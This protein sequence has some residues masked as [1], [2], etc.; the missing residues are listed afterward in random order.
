MWLDAARTSP[1]Q[2]YQFFL[3]ADDRDIGKLLRFLTFVPLEEITALEAR[4][5]SAPDVREGQRVLA[6]EIVRL[7]HGDEEARKAEAATQALFGGKAQEGAGA[8]VATI[9][10]AEAAGAPASSLARA[11]LE[12]AG[13]PLPQLLS[14]PG[15]ALCSSLSDARRQIGQ[16]GIYL[17]EERVGDEKRV[18]TAADLL[19]G[20]VLLL[21]KG[22]KSYHIVRVG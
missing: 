22:K 2:M 21:R 1:Y 20:G 5:V 7:V 12:G 16:G 15:V 13:L 18:V 9:T 4:A 11:E 19:E 3:N 14:R 8:V 6:R 17:N 10:A